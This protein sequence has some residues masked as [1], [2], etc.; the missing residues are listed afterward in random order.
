M[1]FTVHLSRRPFP[2]LAWLLCVI[3]LWVGSAGLCRTQDARS[4]DPSPRLRLQEILGFEAPAPGT[5]PPDWRFTPDGT[6]SF[7]SQTPH[8]GLRAVRFERPAE[9]RQPLSTV[10]TDIPMDF[11]CTRIEP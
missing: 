4:E 11:A 8:S 2:L 7:D 5:Q 6:V 9:G 10:M 3:A 1:H